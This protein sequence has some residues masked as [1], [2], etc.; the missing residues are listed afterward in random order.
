M[1]RFHFG[2]RDNENGDADLSLY[3]CTAKH[4]RIISFHHLVERTLVARHTKENEKM[5]VKK[6]VRKEAFE[7]VNVTSH[8]HI[9]HPLPLQAGRMIQIMTFGKHRPKKLAIKFYY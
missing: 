4:R 7:D 1:R 9:S 3:W 6:E 5:K 8:T 2:S